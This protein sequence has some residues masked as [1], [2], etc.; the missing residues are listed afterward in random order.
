MPFSSE[1]QLDELWAAF[2]AH[3][4][5]KSAWTHQA[6]LAIAGILV[7]RDPESALDRARSGILS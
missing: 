3:T 6:H 1:Q 4:L 2:A 5:P 7:W